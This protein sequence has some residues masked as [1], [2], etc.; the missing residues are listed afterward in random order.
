MKTHSFTRITYFTLLL[1]FLNLFVRSAAALPNRRVEDD[2]ILA[3]IARQAEFKAVD[4]P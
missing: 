1:T 3:I 2:E 4:V